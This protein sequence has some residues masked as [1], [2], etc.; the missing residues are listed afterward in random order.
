MSE[1]DEITSIWLSGFT[2]LA[3]VIGIAL[4]IFLVERV[5]RRAL[6]LTSLFMVTLS[7]FGLGTSFFLARISS[8]PVS[9]SHGLCRSQPAIVWSGITSYCYDCTRIESC[10]FCSGAC[11]E[12]NKYG[13]LDPAMCPPSGEEASSEPD[14]VFDTCQ[15]KY[16]WMSVFFMV[17]YLLSFGIGMGGL[18]WTI[19]SEIYPLQHRSLA[20]SFSTATNWM[21]NL[22]VSATFLT[23]S[24]E[25][26]LTTYGKALR[27]L[28]SVETRNCTADS[29][30]SSYFCR[31]FLALWG[32]LIAGS[33]LDVLLSSRD[34]R[35]VVGGDR[36]L[37]PQTQR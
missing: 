29:L 16:G 34:K 1:F 22:I 3:Q 4:S 15:N 35:L 21:G 28:L 14:W 5:G 10:G 33:F 18:P 7:L 32:D 13:P 24:S 2:A 31:C 36:G 11:V 19:N 26:V 9:S 12:G 17:L 27:V 30:I 23:I 25:A 8:L 37:V 6:V 20:V